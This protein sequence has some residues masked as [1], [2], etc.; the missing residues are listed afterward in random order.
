MIYFNDIDREI[1]EKHLH[2]DCDELV[3]I[4]GYLGPNPILN[5]A[6]LPI[7]SSVIY[8]MYTSDGI[9]PK[10]HSTLLNVHNSSVNV[11]IMYSK[12][13]VHSKCYIW[14]KASDIVHA[15]VGS[16]NF[17]SSG[18]SKPYKEVLSEVFSSAYPNLKSYINYVM[19]NS[20]ICTSSSVRTSVARSRRISTIRSAFGKCSVSL[21]DLSLGV[22]PFRS[23]LNWGMTNLTGSHTN[24][25]DAYIP[26]LKEYIRSHPELFPPKSKTPRSHVSTGRRQRHNEAIDIIWDDGT[27]MVGLL[28]GTQKD[29]GV[30]Y[31]KQI[32]SHPQK[33]ILGQYI[34]NRLGVPS[35]VPITTNHLNAYGRNNIEISLLSDDVYYFDFSKP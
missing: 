12:I 25:D 32:A 1:F 34:R 9:A 28:E 16:A 23:G 31:P 22:V 26:I 3:I 4:S 17:S 8:G 18:L 27:T 7:K 5:L 21:L 10:L 20:L 35:G 2:I 29:N 15:L 30:D 6:S 24:I 33:K 14:L 13:V 19:S 11:D